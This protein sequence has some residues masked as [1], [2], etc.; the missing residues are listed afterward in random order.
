M[1]GAG[2]FEKLVVDMVDDYP[3]RMAMLHGYVGL[4]EGSRLVVTG[5]CFVF[6][7][8]LGMSSSQLTN[9][10]L[11]QRGLFNHQPAFNHH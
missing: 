6:S 11:F 1:A 9:S 4:P 10:N 5:T 2:G 7:I 3:L 8:Q